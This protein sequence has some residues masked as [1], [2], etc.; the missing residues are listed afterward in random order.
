[1]GRIVMITK[2]VWD[3]RWTPSSQTVSWYQCHHC[4]C[5]IWTTGS[6]TASLPEGAIAGVTY[7]HGF[8]HCWPCLKLYHRR[9]WRLRVKQFAMAKLGV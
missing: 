9:G 2:L 1:M 6:Q 3:K 4:G 5:P 8:I 7:H